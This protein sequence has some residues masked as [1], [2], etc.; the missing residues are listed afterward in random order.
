MDIL[1]LALYMA[2]SY[3]LPHSETISFAQVQSLFNDTII[4]ISCE[5]QCHFGT[6]IGT[7]PFTENPVSKKTL[8]L[9]F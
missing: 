3:N 7:R 1:A 4:Q 9:R 2:T 5:G 6:A 8:K